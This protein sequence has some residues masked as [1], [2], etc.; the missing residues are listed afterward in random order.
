M[1]KNVCFSLS[2]NKIISYSV[3]SCHLN[4]LSNRLEEEH[5]DV[6]IFDCLRRLSVADAAADALRR[7]RHRVPV[8]RMQFQSN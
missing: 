7:R 1:E 8:L 5:G 4:S 3:V 6:E 2:Q